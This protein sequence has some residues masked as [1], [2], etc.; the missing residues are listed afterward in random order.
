MGGELPATRGC[1]GAGLAGD[2]S[3]PLRGLAGG[4]GGG[5]PVHVSEMLEQLHARMQVKLARQGMS[6]DRETL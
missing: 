3:V 2:I 5:P 4:I 6:P 1:S